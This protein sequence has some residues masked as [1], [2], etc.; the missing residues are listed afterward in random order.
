MT[1]DLPY[2][3]LAI[4]LDRTLLD[5][6]HRVPERNRAA[7]HRAHERGLKV[8]LCTGR[9]F[10]ETRPILDEIGLELD[11]AVT[12]GGA[13][14]SNARTGETLE[15]DE[16]PLPLAHEITHWLLEQDYSVLWLTDPHAIGFDGYAIERARQHAAYREWRQLTPCRFESTAD[17]PQRG[18][19]PMRLTVVDD[20][21]I[22]R[23]LA[24]DLVARFARR[25]SHNVLL[26]PR[27]GFTVIEIFDAPVNKW[28][29][30][31]RLCRRWRLDPRRTI[32][33][34]DDVNDLPL[35]AMAGLGVAVDNAQP[36]VKAVANRTCASND[37]CGV[38][39]VIDALLAGREI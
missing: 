27:P 34:G 30:I 23:T 8:V 35:L 26:V 25:V 16:I 39:D 12:V 3:L 22:L 20:T 14:L 10:T 13:L 38:A 1:A 4:D 11:A 28:Y 9:A 31:E 7:L 6:T 29:G 19:A 36:A 37:D 18:P 32:A 5:S 15:R 17:L 33:I 21:P 2:D 24:D